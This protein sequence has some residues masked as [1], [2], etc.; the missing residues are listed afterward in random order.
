MGLFK[1][2]VR[3]DITEKEKDALAFM[4]NRVVSGLPVSKNSVFQTYFYEDRIMIDD[5]SRTF[6]LNLEKIEDI[7][8]KTDVEIQKAMVSSAGGAVAGGMIFGPIGAIVGGRT[9]EK[10][11]R[12]VT[13]YLIITY[14]SNEEQKYISF[15]VTYD[16]KR[17]CKFV[18][19]FNQRFKKV[20]GNKIVEL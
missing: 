19:V 4:S 8:M 17:A 9:K 11:I 12:D 14:G 7:C 10:E 6:N 18:E 13:T 2:K 15:N 1:P 5:G 16:Y 20:E 3:K